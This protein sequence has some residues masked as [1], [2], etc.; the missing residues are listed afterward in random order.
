[1]FFNFFLFFFYLSSIA[2]IL[3][4]RRRKDAFQNEIKK[5]NYISSRILCMH[6]IP[7]LLCIYF[8]PLTAKVLKNLKPIIIIIIIIVDVC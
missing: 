2:F 8:N 1:M 5:K 4:R 6:T 3:I 7:L